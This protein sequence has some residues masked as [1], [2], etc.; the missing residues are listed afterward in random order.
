MM[1]RRRESW[2][3]LVDIERCDGPGQTPY[4]QVFSYETTDEGTT[5]AT[6][7][8]ELNERTPLLDVDGRPAAPIRWECG[9]LQ[10]KCGACAMVID[11]VPRAACDVRLSQLR[12]K[13][14]RLSPLRKFPL[15]ADLVVDRKAVYGRLRE[16]EAWLAH[17]VE[18]PTGKAGSLAYEASRCLECGCCLEVCPNFSTV[19]AFG[20]MA[21]MVPLARLLSE[22]SDEDS[23]RIAASY[24]AA[25]FSGCGKSLACRNVCPAGIDLAHLMSRSNAAAVWG[26]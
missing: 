13:V 9:C 2:S 14:V 10:R 3:V 1:R 4:H 6:L 16:I 26:R 21:A 7:L 24:R 19:G 12:G 5:V 23:S 20:G 17:E 8:R 11:G 18:L 25:V 22:A 15:V